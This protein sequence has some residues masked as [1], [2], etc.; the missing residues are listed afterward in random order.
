MRR[1]LQLAEAAAY[2][3]NSLLSEAVDPKLFGDLRSLLAKPLDQKQ[4]KGKDGD[5]YLTL[6]WRQIAKMYNKPGADPDEIDQEVL[7]YASSMLRR[8]DE[9]YVSL[10]RLQVQN[11]IGAKN[12]NAQGLFPDDGEKEFHVNNHKAIENGYDSLIIKD[13]KILNKLVKL[14]IGNLPSQDASSFGFRI[15]VDKSILY[16]PSNL[17]KLLT[18]VKAGRNDLH[19]EMDFD[20]DIIT[21]SEQ[22]TDA[23]KSLID[24]NPSGLKTVFEMPFPKVEPT[25]FID[26][27]GEDI[28]A[29]GDVTLLWLGSIPAD[30]QRKMNWLDRRI[31]AGQLTSYKNVTPPG[32]RPKIAFV[33]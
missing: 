1:T 26:E 7:P 17:K 24:V 14:K 2:N 16:S 29:R 3:T 5:T 15:E 33:F 12:V 9:R 6:V 8:M 32:G 13:Q 22:M 25:D 19:L 4:V 11:I 23:F 30:H 20:L 31:K 21:K 18:W 10:S 27:L 28:V